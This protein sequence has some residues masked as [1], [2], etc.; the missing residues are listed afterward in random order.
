MDNPIIKELMKLGVFQVILAEGDNA[1]HCFH[2]E[3]DSIDSI[4]C[5]KIKNKE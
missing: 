4:M 3:I 1:F 5:I 2:I